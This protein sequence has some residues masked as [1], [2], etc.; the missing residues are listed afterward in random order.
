[1]WTKGNFIIHIIIM[2]AHI[3]DIVGQK[4]FAL[5]KAMQQNNLLCNTRCQVI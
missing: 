2:P 4:V 5:H 1:M 3:H